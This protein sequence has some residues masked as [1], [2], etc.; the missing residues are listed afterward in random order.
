[1]LVCGALTVVAVVGI[2]RGA[3]PAGDGTITACYQRVN[4]NMRVIDTDVTTTC[5]RQEGQLTWS[6]AG[7]A[8]STGPTG[9]TGATGSTGATGPAGATGATGPAGATGA[10]GPAG[11]A[12]VGAASFN[13]PSALVGPG[14]GFAFVGRPATSR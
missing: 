1:L 8:G 2:A 4:G 5:G 6:Q 12:T 9:A 11:S 14:T 13:G 7:P 10:T 3:I